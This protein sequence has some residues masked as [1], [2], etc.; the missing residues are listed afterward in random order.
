MLNLRNFQVYLKF[1]SSYCVLCPRLDYKC[2]SSV[3][4][5]RK[6]ANPGSNLP[7][8]VIPDPEVDFYRDTPVRYLGYANEVGE[9]FRAVIHK[10]VVTASYGIASLYVLADVAAKTIQAWHST[11]RNVSK[12]AKIGTDALLWQSLA[13]VI[14]PGLAINR[15]CHL[16]R[17]YIFAQS[18]HC[19]VATV[20]LGLVAI[21]CVVH[22]IDWG[23][24]RAMDVTV[25]PYLLH[26]HVDHTHTED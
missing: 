26:V 10:H 2:H 22:P 4:M 25:R 12:V 24:S 16:G 18:R 3:P 13:S 8:D 17:V 7:D 11:D 23:V 5:D 6:D 21:P 14:I 1:S 19:R 20:A 15:I 9:A